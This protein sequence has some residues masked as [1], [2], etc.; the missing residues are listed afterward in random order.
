MSLFLCLYHVPFITIDLEYNLKLE[1][2]IS[3]TVLLLF[4]IVLAILSFLCFHMKM[5]IILSKSVNECVGILM[6]LC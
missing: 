3:P 1:I 5:E 6:G 4:R 2:V